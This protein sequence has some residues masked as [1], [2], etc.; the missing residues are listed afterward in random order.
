MIARSGI[1]RHS[2]AALNIQVGTWPS[3]TPV[4]SR[5]GTVVLVR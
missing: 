4:R 1:G 2:A 5:L 3:W